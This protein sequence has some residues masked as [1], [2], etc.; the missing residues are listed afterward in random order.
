MGCGFSA[1]A[2]AAAQ[3]PPPGAE[4][5]R[6]RPA[7]IKTKSQ[8]AAQTLFEKLGGADV[9]MQ[10]VNMF[11]RKMMVDPLLAPFFQHIDLATLM[12]KQ[13]REKKGAA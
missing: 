4:A 11:Y 1:P 5:V 6:E 7:V 13:V 12:R 3:G 8:Q 2:A 10:A 9:V